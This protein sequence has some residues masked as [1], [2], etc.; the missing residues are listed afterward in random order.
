MSRVVQS[1]DMSTRN[2]C[3]KACSLCLRLV[4]HRSFEQ[5][6]LGGIQ[7]QTVTN[8]GHLVCSTAIEKHGQSTGLLLC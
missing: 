6:L 4:M 5:R 7:G 3:L 2:R 8:R 1:I